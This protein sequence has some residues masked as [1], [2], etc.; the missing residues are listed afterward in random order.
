MKKGVIAVFVKTP[1]YSPVKTRLAKKIGKEKSIEFFNL[2]VAATQSILV[3]VKSE[4]D[5]IEIFWAIAEAEAIN[6]PMWSHQK[7]ILQGEGS[8]G[9]RLSKVYSELKAD[10]EFVALIGAD[11]PH[12][13]SQELKKCIL[14][15][16][17]KGEYSIGET[18][19]GGFYFMSGSKEIPHNSWVEVEYSAAHTARQLN[20]EL[21]KI[22]SVNQLDKNFD[23]D[24]FEDLKKIKESHLNETTEQ[25]ELK[26][27]ILKQI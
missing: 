6:H 21:S 20:R 1:D 8:L 10:Y 18:E 2:S 19:D 23:I 24:E 22:G 27:W 4:L 3:K 17:Q 13:T 12:L 14:V 15:S 5:N 16:L 11:S 7:I 9:E 26:K 25:K